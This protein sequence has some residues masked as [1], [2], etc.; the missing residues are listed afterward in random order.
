[1]DMFEFVCFIGGYGVITAKPE[2]TVQDSVSTFIS[3]K[4]VDILNKMS[5]HFLARLAAT[6][7]DIY[8]TKSGHFAAVFVETPQKQQFLRRYQDFFGAVL[9]PTKL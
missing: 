7:K 9:V 6:I 5:G 3:L 8:D 1:M 4:L 2:T